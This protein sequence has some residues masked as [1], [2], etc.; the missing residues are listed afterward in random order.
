VNGWFVQFHNLIDTPGG[1]MLGEMINKVYGCPQICFRV[2]NGFPFLGPPEKPMFF[3]KAI[4]IGLRAMTI[5][6]IPNTGYYDFK[7]LTDDGMRLYYQKIS[8]QDNLQATMILND[9]NIYP[10]WNIIINSWKDQAE[11]WDTSNKMY[12]N[13]NDL[14]L[15]RL[16]YYQL[17]GYASACIKLRRYHDTSD[18]SDKMTE[19]DIP[20]K[21]T[22]CSLLWSEVP[23][24]GIS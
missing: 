4:N 2:K 8:S 3:P 16:D 23:L 13:E 21:N 12:F 1:M 9:K 17:A 20:Y 11:V 19:M 22:F 7:I 14:L 6:K 5:L 18:K 24:L 10:P 15:I